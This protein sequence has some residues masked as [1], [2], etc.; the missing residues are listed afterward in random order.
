MD[1]QQ[2][3]ETKSSTEKLVLE[4]IF[5]EIAHNMFHREVTVHNDGRVQYSPSRGAILDSFSV[6][7]DIA[8]FLEKDRNEELL[9]K[10]EPMSQ[11]I[12][13]EEWHRQWNDGYWLYVKRR[14]RDEVIP[15]MNRKMEELVI[16][17]VILRDSRME[18]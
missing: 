12:P 17:G 5:N 7:F 4:K 11:I 13:M 6:G 9:R 3:L 10:L 14:E 1:T 15:A 2:I 8:Q 16:Q 18:T